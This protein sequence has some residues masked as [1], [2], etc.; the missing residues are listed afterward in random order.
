[1]RRRAFTLIELLVVIAIIAVL[2]ALL[3]PAVQSAREAARR[4]Q[5]VNNLK[6]L[7]L[8]TSNYAA[9][10]DGTIP[11]I[12][13]DNNNYAGCTD[14]SLNQQQNFSAHT[15]LLPYLE[16]SPTYN[17]INFY[18]GARWGPGISGND[19]DAGGLYS[20]INGTV[21]TTQVS[22]FLCPSDPNPGRAGN[23]QVVVGQNAPYPFT[24]T[25]NY[26]NTLGTNRAYNNWIANGPAYIPSNW[27]TNLQLVVGL[28]SFTDGTSNTAI[29]GE[30][31]KGSGVDPGS[32]PDKNVL[33]MVYGNGGD[34]PGAPS[35]PQ[36]PT[37]GY[38][39]DFAAAQVCQNTVQPQYWSWKGE[40]AYYGKTMH[41]TH[42]QLPNRKSCS[43]GDW[44]RSGEMV[45]ASSNHPGGVNLAF[46]D[47]SV[48]FIKSTVNPQ[49]WYAL[50]TVAGREPVSGNS[51]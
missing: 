25:C 29:Y 17:M 42:T 4:A 43:A 49:S 16:Q 44:C 18:F 34:I 6:Q 5:C 1:M 27:D 21:I 36:I 40:W 47:G 30:W 13:V 45:A 50:A 37:A 48:H 19:P 20:V 8:A 32:G 24:A 2:I 28:N 3:L 51:Y 10:N 15:R 11:P 31:V 26:P 33:G 46:M 9:S 22:A 23:S 39:N 12:F 41:Y 14:G 35:S 38:A 7:A